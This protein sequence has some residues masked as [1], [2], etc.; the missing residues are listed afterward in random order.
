VLSEVQGNVQRHRWWAESGYHSAAYLHLAGKG[1]QSFPGHLIGCLAAVKSP[2]EIDRHVA[3]IVD[4][5]RPEISM[6]HAA[7]VVDASLAAHVRVTELGQ[8]ASGSGAVLGRNQQ[9]DIEVA[10]LLARPVQRLC[11]RRAFQDDRIDTSRSK[12]F[13]G[14]SRR[15][16]EVGAARSEP[17]AGDEVLE[18]LP[19][20]FVRVRLGAH[21]DRTTD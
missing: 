1:A 20:L 11:E 2:V 21:P 8:N 3:E 9:I 19:P 13:D 7:D 10:S 12:G 14:L 15:A 17:A 16:V 4:A 5:A 6:E 18:L